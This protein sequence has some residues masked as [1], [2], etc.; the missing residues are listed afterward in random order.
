MPTNFKPYLYAA[1]IALFAV[2]VWYNGRSRYLDGQA[3]VKAELAQAYADQAKVQAERD[4]LAAQIAAVSKEQ[5]AKDKAAAEATAD[6]IRKAIRDI[7]KDHPLPG[8]CVRP[9]GVQEQLDKARDSANA[10]VG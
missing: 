3:S 4:K 6:A 5:L 9:P 8:N 1:L 2:G 10:S 7:Y